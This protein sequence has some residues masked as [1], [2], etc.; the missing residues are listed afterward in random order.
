MLE[1][2]EVRIAMK[3]GG[4]ESVVEVLIKVLLA[5]SEGAPPVKETWLIC[6]PRSGQTE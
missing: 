5:S 3:E 6:P 2:F 1:M 4:P